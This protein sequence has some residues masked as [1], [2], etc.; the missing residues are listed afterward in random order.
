MDEKCNSDV[1]QAAKLANV[2][3]WKVADALGMSDCAFSRKLRK[4]LSADEKAHIFSVVE[5]LS[6]E[7]V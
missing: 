5:Q 6:R 3:L 7:A 4:E 1:R 2:R